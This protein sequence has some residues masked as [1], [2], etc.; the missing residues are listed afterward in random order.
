M[1]TAVAADLLAG[2]GR[3]ALTVRNVAQAAG[4]STTIVSHYFDDMAELLA[5][6]N[7]LAARRAR[8]RVDAVLDA[9]A[10][11]LVGL[12]EA[13]LP[14]DDVR[15]ADWRVWLAFW[16]EAL[17]VEAFA[18][19]QRQRAAAMVTRIERCL[20]VLV[21]RGEIDPVGVDVGLAA[22]RIGA[23]VQGVAAEAVFDPD[24]WGPARQRAVI[25]SELRLLGVTFTPTI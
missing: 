16:S 17:S 25:A 12:L 15:L 10:A 2:H 19:E 18:V 6:T 14:L 13:V 5:E 20:D 7:T 11:D 9:D 3:P 1:V 4:C 22:F 23:L 24:A 8:T 21:A